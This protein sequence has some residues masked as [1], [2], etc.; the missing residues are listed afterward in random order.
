MAE[1]R[2]SRLKLLNH[3]HKIE[4]SDSVGNEQD[5]RFG[6]AQN[7]AQFLSPVDGYD[8]V[9]DQATDRGCDRQRDRLWDIRQLKSER[10]TGLYAK[11]LNRLRQSVGLSPGVVVRQAHPGV[12]EQCGV[13][14]VSA[15]TLFGYR[16]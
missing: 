8:R 6:V 5:F 13:L 16:G 4:S 11:R 9:D 1:M 15:C 12:K 10:R 3:L 14:R 7:K 2:E